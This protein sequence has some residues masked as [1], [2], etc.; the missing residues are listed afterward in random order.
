MTKQFHSGLLTTLVACS[1]TMACGNYRP[2]ASPQS[3]DA[4]RE[5]DAR[6]S[7]GG[8]AI[9]IGA[10]AMLFAAVSFLTDKEPATPSPRATGVAL[11]GAAFAFAGTGIAIGGTADLV[12]RGCGNPKASSSDASPAATKSDPP[13]ES[14]TKK[15]SAK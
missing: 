10:V 13:A 1:L 12:S 8:G 6:V 11:G 2:P 15:P 4:C 3:V 5:A 14:N 9:I 7:Q